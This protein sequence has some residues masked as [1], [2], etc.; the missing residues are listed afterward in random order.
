MHPARRF[1]AVVDPMRRRARTVATGGAVAIALG[2]AAVAAVGFGGDPSG[3]HRASD[4][5]PATAQVTRQ[6]M[7]DTDEMPGE[8]GYGATTTLAGRIAGVVT[9]V[10]LAGDVGPQIRAVSARAAITAVFG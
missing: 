5:P 7:V 6:T 3:S 8:L 9:G 2:A 1:R 4:L 10:P